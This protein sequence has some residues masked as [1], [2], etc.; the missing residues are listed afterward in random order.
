[1]NILYITLDPLQSSSSA[2]ERNNQI[3]KALV[4]LDYSIDIITIGQNPYETNPKIKLFSLN[5]TEKY[6]AVSKHIIIKKMIKKIYYKFFLFDNTISLKNAKVPS[7]FFK[8][9]YDYIISSSDPKTSHILTKNIIERERLSYSKWIQYWGDPLTGDISNN[10]I[11][12]KKTI[13]S[14]ER[15]IYNHCTSIIFVSPFTLITQQNNH[16]KIIDRM[17]FV[18]VPHKHVKTFEN[19]GNNENILKF[20]YFGSYYSNIRNILPTYKAFINQ[21]SSILNVAGNSNIKLESRVNIKILDNQPLAILSKLE[22]ETDVYICILNKKGTQIPGKLYH[23][24]GTTKPIIVIIDGKY[25]SQMRKYIESFN[26]FIVCDNT[27]SD[28]VSVLSEKNLYQ[29]YEPTNKLDK[30]VIAE[31]ILKSQSY[32]Y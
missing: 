1:M 32:V 14:I 10:T 27:V 4:D 16:P 12:P 8:K 28:I 23:Y 25:K 19:Y 9:H 31:M 30:K 15:K 21:K 22:F 6:F 7:S 2:S 17:H 3:I 26:R 11:W 20:G 18:P 5:R 29:K 13:I 24:A